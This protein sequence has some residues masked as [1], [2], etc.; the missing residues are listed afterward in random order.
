[1]KLTPHIL[2]G[3]AALLA[4]VPA[5]AHH[6]FFAQFDSNAPV[7]LSGTITGVEWRNPH[8]WVSLAVENADGSVTNWRCEGGAP[9]ALVRRGWAPNTL[10]VGEEL[11]LFGYVAFS[12]PNVC[13]ARTWTYRGVTIFDGENDGGPAARAEMQNR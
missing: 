3:T 7:E 11:A 13:N 9:N 5:L 4:T 10:Q 6:S 1:M 2:I 8:I 12:H